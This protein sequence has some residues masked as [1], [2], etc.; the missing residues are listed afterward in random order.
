ME[1]KKQC[2]SLELAKQLKSLNVKQESLY[3][4]NCNTSGPTLWNEDYL[5]QKEWKHPL[6]IYSAYTASELGEMLP[7]S[8]PGDVE[9]IQCRCPNEVKLNIRKVWDGGKEVWRV[10][11]ADPMKHHQKANCRPILSTNEADAR[12]KMLI[13]LL[14]NKLI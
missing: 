4:W 6:D 13:Y 10:H 7:E 3:Y 11:Y 9:E 12:A 14:E 5:N 1:L 2:V 8:I